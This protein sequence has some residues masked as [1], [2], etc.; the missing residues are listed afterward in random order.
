LLKHGAKVNTFNKKGVTP[1]YLAVENGYV[2]IFR[3]LLNNGAKV[4]TAN[5]DGWTPL[6]AAAK[7]GPMELVL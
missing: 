2:G 5:M 6:H 7:F 3:E 1:L 4:D